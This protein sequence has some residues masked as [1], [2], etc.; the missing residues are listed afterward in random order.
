M[1]K[2]TEEEWELYQRIAAGDIA[3]SEADLRE[4]VVKSA[5]HI[6][7]LT[8]ERDEAQT[9]LAEANATKAD[10]LRTIERSRRAAGDGYLVLNLADSLGCGTSEVYKAVSDLRARVRALEEVLREVGRSRRTLKPEAADHEVDRRIVEAKSEP[11]T[12]EAFAT[13]RTIVTGV[14]RG[15]EVS[16]TEGDRLLSLL[17]RRM[18]ALERTL[19][20]VLEFMPEHPDFT[21]PNDADVYAAVVRA[22][23]LLSQLTTE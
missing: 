11:T 13:V 14:P 10:M 16:S 8:A 4:W 18:G 2:M 17:E 23:E 12:A 7:A 20:E 6:M 15:E 21:D 9:H 1:T 19:G 5:A 3:A 22:R